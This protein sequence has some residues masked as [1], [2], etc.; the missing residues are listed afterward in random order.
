MEVPIGKHTARVEGDTLLLKLVGEFTLEEFE[1]YASLA[2]KISAEHGYLFV[3]DDLASLGG[4]A[5]VARRR[6]ADWLGKSNCRGAALCGTSQT[7][8]ALTGLV[9]GAVRMLGWR[10]PPIAFCKTEQE[11]RDWVAAQRRKQQAS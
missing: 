10:V 9:L 1:R 7:S 2:D 8:R 6:A 11:A 3:I 4:M 5:P